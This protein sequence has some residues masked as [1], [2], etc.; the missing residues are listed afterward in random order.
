MATNH[1]TMK[2]APEDVF[3]VIANGWFFPTWVVGAS[4]MRDVDETW[5]HVGS[6]LHHSFGVWPVLINDETTSLQWDPPHRVVMQPKGW[7]LGEARVV[8]EV[9]PHTKGCRVTIVEHAVKGPGTLLPRTAL[10]VALFIRNVE[11]LKRLAFMAEAKA[12]G[13]LTG[14]LQPTEADQKPPKRASHGLLRRVALFGIAVIAV[15]VVA[16]RISESQ[17]VSRR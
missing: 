4:R 11:T 1:R 6:H 7:P 9:K 8:V 12:G 14:D 13:E 3:T 15:V 17:S 16:Q 5:P 10:D 2:C